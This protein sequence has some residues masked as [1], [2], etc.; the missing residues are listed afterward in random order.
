[1]KRRVGGSMKWV[2]MI[3][4]SIN[5][6]IRTF[7]KETKNTKIL[8]SFGLFCSFLVLSCVFFLFWVFSS[9]QELLVA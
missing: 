1:M 2:W 7:T 5:D 6:H 9:I 4:I 8:F 3:M